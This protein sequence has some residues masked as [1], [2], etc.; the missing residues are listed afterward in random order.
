MKNQ[1]HHEAAREATNEYWERREAERFTPLFHG[2][3]PPLHHMLTFAEI[4]TPRTRLEL[5][6]QDW[7]DYRALPPI[8]L[9]E[10]A[11]F[12]RVNGLKDFNNQV[13]DARRSVE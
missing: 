4:Y 3:P 6:E 11:D 2:P 10:L 12:R 1:F 9:E 7:A 8:S 13:T 5:D